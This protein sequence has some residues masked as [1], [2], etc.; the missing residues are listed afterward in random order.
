MEKEE[1]MIALE[2]IIEIERTVSLDVFLKPMVDGKIHYPS[3]RVG[4]Q[5]HELI[6]SAKADLKELQQK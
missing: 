5:A 3:Q 1:L 4:L 2:K 6:K